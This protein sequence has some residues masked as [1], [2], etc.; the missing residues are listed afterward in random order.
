MELYCQN[1]VT[2]DGFGLVFGFIEHL[3]L[4]TTCKDYAL[5]VLH[6]LQIIIGHTRSSESV[7]LH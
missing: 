3:Q 1:L 6:N 7:S 2:M 4:V 5:T